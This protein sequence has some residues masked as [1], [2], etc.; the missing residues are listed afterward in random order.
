[1]K[2]KPKKTGRPT[3]KSKGLQKR[4]EQFSVTLTQPLR[5]AIESRAKA[6]KISRTAVVQSG[7]EKAAAEW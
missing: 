3:N 7:M 6:L 2:T 5:A 1:M 4:A